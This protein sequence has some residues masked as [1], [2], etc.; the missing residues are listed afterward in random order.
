MSLYANIQL[1]FLRL[2]D[3]YQGQWISGLCVEVVKDE[4]VKLERL[5][6]TERTFY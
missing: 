3:R 2:W 5:I 1:Q 6:S 4:I